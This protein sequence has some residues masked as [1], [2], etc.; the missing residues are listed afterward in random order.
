MR[1][2]LQINNKHMSDYTH[3]IITLIDMIGIRELLNRG[4]SAAIAKMRQMHST[5]PKSAI[6]FA[7]DTEICFWNDS[8]L[9]HS[10]VELSDDS[11]VSAMRPIVALKA[12]IDSVCHS[13]AICVKGKS[14]PSPNIPPSPDKNFRLVYLSASSLAFT[15]CFDVEAAVKKAHYKK[16]WYID[17]RIIRR[18]EG[19]LSRPADLKRRFHLYPRGERRA[20]HMFNDLFVRRDA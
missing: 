9:I 10:P 17:S 12:A 13:Y 2:M 15:N 16:N 8:V 18:V 19:T 4:D 7:K 5:I 3:C 6:G 20:F 11:F 14:F 1:A